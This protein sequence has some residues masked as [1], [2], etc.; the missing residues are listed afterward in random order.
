MVILPEN[1][2]RPSQQWAIE[3]L[4]AALNAS[5]FTQLLLSGASTALLSPEYFLSAPPLPYDVIYPSAS[6]PVT[7]VQ[8]VESDALAAHERSCTRQLSA[9]AKSDF[10]M[11]ATAT[12]TKPASASTCCGDRV[13][14]RI[15]GK[16][17]WNVLFDAEPLICL[18]FDLFDFHFFSPTF[19]SVIS[20]N[21]QTRGSLFVRRK[22][23]DCWSKPVK[24]MPSCL[25]VRW[26]SRSSF[27]PQRILYRQ[28]D[29]WSQT[30][31]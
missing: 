29:E 25:C 6:D 31:V 13:H 20:L 16:Q 22:S 18:R 23:P 8:I 9:F 26:R 1:D 3:L 27:Y 7:H 11:C 2:E 14:H 17:E 21:I 28:V 12:E 24:S 30:H 10:T 15:A 5:P 4:W 19:P